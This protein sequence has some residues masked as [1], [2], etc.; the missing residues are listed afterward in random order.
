MGDKIRVF[1]QRYMGYLAIV[2]V[3]AVYIAAAFIQI[4][5]TGKSVARIIADGAIVFLFGTFITQI[6]DAQGLMNGE[7]DETFRA[8]QKLHG[9]TVVKISPYLDKLEHWC[10]DKNR[11]NMKLQRTRILSEEGLLYDDYF[12]EDGSVIP[13]DMTDV[14]AEKL[15]KKRF[16]EKIDAVR[17]CKCVSRAVRLKLTPLTAGELTSE[18]SKAQDPYNFG[19]TKAQYRRQV[20]FGDLISRSGTAIIFG[21][22]SASLIQDFSYAALIWNALQVAI[23]ILVGVT[24]MNNSYLFI[25]SEYRGRIVKKINILEMFFNIVSTENNFQQK[26]EDQD[27]DKIQEHVLH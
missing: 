2:L 1:M 9:E 19:R 16:S 10:T 18:S 23:F 20:S 21:Y 8:S 13:S 4:D 7:R 5:E 15:K 22:Y 3:S 6:F 24:R 17:K 11:E 27:A 26:T 25:T 12:R 14:S